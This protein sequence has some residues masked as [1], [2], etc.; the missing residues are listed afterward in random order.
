MRYISFSILTKMIY[1]TQPISALGKRNICLF[2]FTK[3]WIRRILWIY[4]LFYFPF[5]SILFKHIFLLLGL[6]WSLLCVSLFALLNENHFAFFS[7]YVSIC[8]V[9]IW[10]CAC[11][12]AWYF[13]SNFMWNF[14]TIKFNKKSDWHHEQ[15][16]CL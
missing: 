10:Q 1:W 7:R 6:V 3:W 2:H 15:Q 13:Y 16:L 5:V 12:Y 14:L 8:N 9:S 11:E 4:I